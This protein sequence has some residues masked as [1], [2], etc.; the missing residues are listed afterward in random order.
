MLNAASAGDLHSNSL[1][2]RLG[3][4]RWAAARNDMGEVVSMCLRC[5]RLD[6]DDDRNIALSAFSYFAAGPKGPM[7]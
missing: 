2:C 3:F 1:R 5:G 7:P 6:T 4:H